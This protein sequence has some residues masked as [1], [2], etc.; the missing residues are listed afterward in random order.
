M[1]SSKVFGLSNPFTEPLASGTKDRTHSNSSVSG[2]DTFLAHFGH[3]VPFSLSL[4]LTVVQVCPRW[5]DIVARRPFTDTSLP[6]LDSAMSLKLV[7]LIRAL[8]AHSGHQ[9]L[10]CTEFPVAFQRCPAEH[11]HSYL[12]WTWVYVGLRHLP[13]LVPAICCNAASPLLLSRPLSLR[14]Q[15]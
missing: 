1:S 11:S 9:V 6:P 2:F 12:S 3:H 4:V 5:H 15:S 13:P 7:S 10:L 8:P 14:A